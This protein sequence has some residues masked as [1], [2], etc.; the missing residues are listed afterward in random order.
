MCISISLS[1]QRC[2]LR[3]NSVWMRVNLKCVIVR[4]NYPKGGDEGL[5]TWQRPPTVSFLQIQ[6][7]L[8]LHTSRDGGDGL[9]AATSAQHRI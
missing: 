1:W 7:R 3:Q 6:H 2:L 9:W 4:E 8:R 5:R